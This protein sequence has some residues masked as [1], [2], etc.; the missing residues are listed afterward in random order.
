MDDNVKCMDAR[1]S[2]VQINFASCYVSFHVMDECANLLLCMYLGS[3]VVLF[4]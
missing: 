1:A 3:C 4:M 2:F